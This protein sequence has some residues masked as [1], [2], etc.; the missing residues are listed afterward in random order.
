MNS[1]NLTQSPPGGPKSEVSWL[2]RFAALVAVLAFLSIVLGA[3]GL[4]APPLARLASI[5]RD[6]AA[7]AAILLAV[8]IWGSALGRDVKVVGFLEMILGAAAASQA[9]IGATAAAGVANGF[10]ALAVCSALFTRAEWRW[11]ELK[12]ADLR[13]PSFRQLSVATAAMI[14]VESLLGAAYR[15]GAVRLAPHL[16]LG[17]ASAA[18]ALWMLEVAL[19]KFSSL[20]ELKIA[21][22]LTAELVVLQIFLGLVVHGMELN[23]RAL[24]RP[25]PGL[26]VLSATHAAAAALALAASLFT[27]LEAFKYL[28]SRPSAPLEK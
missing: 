8:W 10:F 11:D 21:S 14:F 19:N 24:A 9:A 2:H 27:A 6:S 7:A 13:A 3:G 4:S 22:V 17:V 16:I 23:A 12:T 18:G 25:L 1:P 20:R 28:S 26:A 5:F 15:A